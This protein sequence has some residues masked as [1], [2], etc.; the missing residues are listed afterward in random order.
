MRKDLFLKLFRKLMNNKTL[1]EDINNHITNEELVGMDTLFTLTDKEL[2]DILNS[3]NDK[4]IYAKIYLYLNV[5][6]IPSSIRDL[7]YDNVEVIPEQVY[8]AIS[9][10]QSVK[11]DMEVQDIVEI[12]KSIILSKSKKQAEYASLVANFLSGKSLDNKVEIINLI[13]NAEDNYQAQ[14]AR[15]ICNAAIDACNNNE[16]TILDAASRAFNANYEVIEPL[17]E[18]YEEQYVG[19]LL[20]TYFQGSYLKAVIEGVQ[21]ID[22]INITPKTIIKVKN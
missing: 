2:E 1:L 21:N 10:L 16:E 5:N 12:S 20:N 6:K 17:K 11:D 15:G 18:E 13:A 7:F 8:Y 3:D 4:K 9:A 14:Q 22:E 19:A